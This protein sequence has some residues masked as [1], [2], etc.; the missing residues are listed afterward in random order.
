M[1]TQAA[2]ANWSGVLY[3]KHRRR[4]IFKHG[5]QLATMFYAC[6]KCLELPGYK[7][8]CSNCYNETVG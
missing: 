3:K 2:L 7:P 4:M 5:R 6:D 8:L 1:L